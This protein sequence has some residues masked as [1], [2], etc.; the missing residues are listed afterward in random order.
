[1]YKFFLIDLFVPFSIS[2]SSQITISSEQLWS[3]CECS[4]ALVLL[5]SW[6]SSSEMFFQLKNASIAFASPLI[7]TRFNFKSHQSRRPSRFP[8]C[9]ALQTQSD[10]SE[11]PTTSIISWNVNSL[12]ALL[13]KDPLSGQNLVDSYTPDILCLQ[14]SDQV[15]VIL[16]TETRK[17]VFIS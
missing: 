1:M 3:H 2:F 12:R 13:R 16:E 7:H 8:C 15:F 10:S 5:C 6:E 17:V 11:L 14:V 9:A 4:C